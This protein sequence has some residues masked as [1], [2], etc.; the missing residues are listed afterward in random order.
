MQTGFH[1]T[2]V[3]GQ[4]QPECNPPGRAQLFTRTCLVWTLRSSIPLCVEKNGIPWMLAF[5]EV[6]VPQ[7]LH[8]EETGFSHG[9]RGFSF[10]WGRSQRAKGSLLSKSTWAVL[11]LGGDPWGVWSQNM[12]LT[13]PAPVTCLR[14]KGSECTP[15]S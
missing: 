4:G 14:W 9:L 11:V 3:W 12:L 1:G 8:Q 5:F 13:S 15:I 7:C 6:V 10:P 2:K